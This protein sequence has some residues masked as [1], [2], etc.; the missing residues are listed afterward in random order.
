MVNCTALKAHFPLIRERS[1]IM[2]EIQ[3][4]DKLSRIYEEWSL[5]QQEE[6]LNFCTGVRGMKILYDSFF[7][8]ALNSEY[9]VSRLEF[10]LCTVLKK[11]VKILRILPNDST[12]IADETSLLI[13]DIVV[14][15]EDGS[16]ANV[17]IQKIGYAFPGPRCACYGA[18]ML[19]RQYK[20]VRGEK[21]TSFSYHDIRNVYLIVLYEQSPGEFRNFP[22]I[23]YHYGKQKFESGLELDMLQEYV[24]IPLDIFKKCMHNKT[25]T[26]DLEAW[27]TFL[28]EDRPEKIIELITA[29]PAF[30]AMYE[31]L[32]SMCL[33]TERVMEMFSE[34]LRIL[35]RNTVQ[36]MMDEQQ[37]QV[38]EQRKL[39][40]EQNQ[41]IE[42]Q[43]QQIDV[44][45]QQIDEQNQELAAQRRQLEQQAAEIEELKKKLAEVKN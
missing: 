21:G 7:K 25:I 33:N 39:I 44:Q 15:L 45:S 4:N 26:T 35:D 40:E 43:N 31:T 18:D 32:Y 27:L 29:Y 20:R 36:Y 42:E 19:L 6:F 1:E 10:F 2:Q 24:M 22:D 34:E 37:K 41:Q 23:Y 5:R 12:R 11:K 14:E 28:S 30:K 38:E 13:T 8:E 3:T 16:L 9:D 17:E